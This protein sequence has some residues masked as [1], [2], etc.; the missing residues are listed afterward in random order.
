MGPIEALG[1]PFG[2]GMASAAGDPGL[3]ASALGA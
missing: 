1:G 2:S 3:T